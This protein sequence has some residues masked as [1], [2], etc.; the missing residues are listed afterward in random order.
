MKF[1]EEDVM[2]MAHAC[3]ILP[4]RSPDDRFVTT[5]RDALVHLAEMAGDRAINEFCLPREPVL[6]AEEMAGLR[7]E[8]A[9]KAMQVLL[10]NWQWVTA[11][12]PHGELAGSCYRIAVAMLKARDAK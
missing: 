3:G 12:D 8:I 4:T 9:I 6:Y 7:D 5:T 10:P 11:E 1:A 2:S